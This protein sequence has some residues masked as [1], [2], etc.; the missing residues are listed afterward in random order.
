MSKEIEGKK[1]L[2]SVC[3]QPL[4]AAYTVE[5]TSFSSFFFVLCKEKKWA[6]TS[7]VSLFSLYCKLLKKKKKNEIS[8]N[9]AIVFF[10][11]F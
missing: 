6:L 5:S 10:F 11:F 4:S 1:D 2:I 8:K 3:P 7:F 9:A